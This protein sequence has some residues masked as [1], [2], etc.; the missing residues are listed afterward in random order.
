[1]GG[2]DVKNEVCYDYLR[3]VDE[4]KSAWTTSRHMS[5]LNKVLN[6]KLNKKDGGLQKRKEENIVRSRESV[7]SNYDC[8]LSL[9]KD[10]IEIAKAF[11]LTRREICGD[12]YSI[13]EDNFFLEDGEIYCGT[14]GQGGKY[15]EAVCLDK[16]KDRIMNKY[17]IGKRKFYD[18]PTFI[19]TYTNESSYLFD[20]YAKDIDNHYFRREYLKNLKEELKD[21]DTN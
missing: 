8:D 6:L 13:K 18:K 4:T 7:E 3:E 17:K 19:K 11:G 12:K 21:D 20:K 1:M 15:R 16:Y 10:Q 5:A 14:I 2:E 9:Y